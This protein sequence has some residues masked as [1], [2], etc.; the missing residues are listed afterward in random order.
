MSQYQK[1]V[2]LLLRSLTRLAVLCL[3]RY[4]KRAIFLTTLFIE[5]SK[6]SP[7]HKQLLEKLNER[8]H[9]VKDK[10]A[11]LLPAALHRRIWSQRHL[12]IRNQEG[13]FSEQELDGICWRIVDTVPEL[14]RYGDRNKVLEET[15]K[16]VLASFD[17]ASQQQTA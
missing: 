16:V 8:I 12:N 9:I 6:I 14:S 15:R 3:P 17:Y 7:E 1:V 11:L 4:G 10:D 5:I 2:G 13:E